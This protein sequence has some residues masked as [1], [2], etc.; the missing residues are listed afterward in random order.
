M[1]LFFNQY[2]DILGRKLEDKLGAVNVETRAFTLNLNTDDLHK[3]REIPGAFPCYLGVL[4]T[5]LPMKGTA[6]RRVRGTTADEDATINAFFDIHLK[7]VCD[8]LRI[9]ANQ[10]RTNLE[11]QP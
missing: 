3:N 5:T 9:F 2:F 11:N 1:I 10:V 7:Y 8:C 6:H 4:D